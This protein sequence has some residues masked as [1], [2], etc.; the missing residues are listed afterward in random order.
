MLFL[1][2][3]VSGREGDLKQRQK[4]TSYLSRHFK[5][6]YKYVASKLAFVDLFEQTPKNL[7]FGRFDHQNDFVL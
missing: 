5:L 7:T 2:F 6:Y 4:E 1:V 3:S